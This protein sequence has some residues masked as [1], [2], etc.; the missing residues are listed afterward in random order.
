MYLLMDVLIVDDSAQ[1]GQVVRQVLALEGYT[2]AHVRDGSDALAWLARHPMPRLVLVD[3]SMPEMDGPTFIAQ[4]QAH[5]TWHTLPMLVMTAE[6]DF[7]A[8]LRD[9]PIVGV[10]AK[11]F[12]MDDLLRHV[13]AHT[14]LPSAA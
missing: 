9:L 7:A 1:I 13:Q 10:L 2:A 6:P 4:V 12:G 3:L 5:P 14:T 11:P 8:R